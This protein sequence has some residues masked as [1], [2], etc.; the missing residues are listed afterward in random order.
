M[1]NSNYRYIYYN[2][3]GEEFYKLK[4]DPNEWINL[5]GEENSRAIIDKMKKVV[6]SEFS[7]AAT[8]SK[9]LQL[10]I[11]GDSFRWE[12]KN[13]GSPIGGIPEASKL[14]SVKKKK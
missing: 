1:V 6:P 14:V 2:D 9:D 12:H 10:I 4:E 5:A 11:E 7:P 8:S 3:G 13:G